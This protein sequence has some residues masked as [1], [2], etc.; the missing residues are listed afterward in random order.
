MLQEYRGFSWE[1]VQ[2][3]VPFEVDILVNIFSEID[4]DKEKA[5]KNGVT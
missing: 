1:E 2:N 4:K 5:K 3:L